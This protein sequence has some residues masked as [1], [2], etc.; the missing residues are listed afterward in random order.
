[1]VLL[2]VVYVLVL[3]FNSRVKLLVET[4]LQFFVPSALHSIKVA[5]GFL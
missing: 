5:E 3:C 4:L 2:Y 1:M